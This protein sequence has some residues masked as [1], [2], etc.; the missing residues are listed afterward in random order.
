MSLARRLDESYDA[1]TWRLIGAKFNLVIDRDEYERLLADSKE[2]DHR[3]R[4][5]IEL[6]S[7]SHS[8]QIIKQSRVASDRKGVG[9]TRASRTP[10]SGDW[11]VSSTRAAIHRVCKLFHSQVV[12]A[13]YLSVTS[14][15]RRKSAN[16]G[17]W[18]RAKHRSSQPDL[19]KENEDR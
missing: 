12:S 11:G 17:S 3:H 5:Y 15:G 1:Y 13:T 10:S 6:V 4:Q 7:I 9:R 14:R 19:I 18:E 2:V 16:C 8:S